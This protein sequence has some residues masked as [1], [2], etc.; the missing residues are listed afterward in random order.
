MRAIAS[1]LFAAYF[2]SAC[3]TYAP[4]ASVPRTTG[5]T[6]RIY[7]SQ[8][9]TVELEE[10]TASN[11]T[12]VDG[13]IATAMDGEIVVSAWSLRSGSGAEFEA[14]GRSVRFPAD[15]VERV[16]RKEFSWLQ[17]GGVVALGVL[18]GVLFAAAGGSFSGDGNG[19][20]PTGTGK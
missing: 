10:V 13:E 14:A 12:Q 20:P 6:V 19:P 5:E 3:F 17:T 7:L 1:V 11:I 15:A 9:Q 2:C 18:A 16:E 4:A 8:P